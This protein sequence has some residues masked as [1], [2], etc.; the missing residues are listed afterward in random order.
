VL[1]E[2]AR[3][4]NLKLV[5]PAV[6]YCGDC[7][8]EGGVTFTDPVTYLDA[9]FAACKDCRVDAI[10]VHWY[11]CDVSALKWYISRFTKYGKPIWLTEFACGDR[12]HDQITVEVQKKYMVDALDYLENEPAVAR[13]AWFSGRNNEIPAIN[14]L[15]G[16]GQLT[17][18]GRLYVTLPFS[19][20]T[21]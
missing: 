2:V 20:A 10:A 13:Y 1:E 3:R 21:P 7:V 4:K 15:G 18:L 9:F 16:S 11:A 17:D 19:T 8:S 5:S 12:P 6:N 14:L